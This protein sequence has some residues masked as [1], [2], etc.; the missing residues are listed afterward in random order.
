MRDGRPAVGWSYTSP[1]NEHVLAFWGWL[2]DDNPYDDLPLV[3]TSL[4]YDQSAAVISLKF[5]PNPPLLHRAQHE[6]HRQGITFIFD[7]LPNAPAGPFPVE[8]SIDIGW[9]RALSLSLLFACSVSLATYVVSPKKTYNNNNNT[10]EHDL[11]IGFNKICSNGGNNDGPNGMSPVGVFF[12]VVFI[13]LLVAAVAW[14]AYKYF[15]VGSRGW[16]IFPCIIVCRTCKAKYGSGAP[17]AY[18]PQTDY[19]YDAAAEENL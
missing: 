16:D 13:L 12:L 1:I 19:S 2:S 15:Q 9:V 18:G 14:M 3:V 8:A 11:Q 17:T 4:V 7:C 10:Q 6:L 5:S